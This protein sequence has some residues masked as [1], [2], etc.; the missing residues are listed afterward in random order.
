MHG[1]TAG[2]SSMAAFR[3]VAHCLHLV[4]TKRSV[5]LKKNLKIEN[6]KLQN[7]KKICKNGNRV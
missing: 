6:Y 4:A 7:Y 5:I 1:I 3:N 2:E